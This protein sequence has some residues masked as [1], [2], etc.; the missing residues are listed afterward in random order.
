MHAIPH[1]T[2]EKFSYKETLHLHIM[3]YAME[4]ASHDK[5]SE[6]KSFV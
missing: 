1:Y 5:D 6:D 4:L 3:L 2:N